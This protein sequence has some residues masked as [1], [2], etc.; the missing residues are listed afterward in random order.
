MRNKGRVGTSFHSSRKLGAVTVMQCV[1][2]HNTKTPRERC[3]AVG[4]D[5]EEGHKD[6]QRAGVPLL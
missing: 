3:G 1:N 5:P 6:D 2:V 4:V